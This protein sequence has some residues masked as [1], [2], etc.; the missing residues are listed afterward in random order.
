[1]PME[2]ASVAYKHA[3]VAVEIAALTIIPTGAPEPTLANVLSILESDNPKWQLIFRDD[4]KA[5][6]GKGLAMM[7]RTLRRAQE[8]RHGRPDDADASLEEARAAVI[9]AATLIQRFTSGGVVPMP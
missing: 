9:L 6:G 2:R 4:G 8:S 1:M 3:V 7:L 5:P